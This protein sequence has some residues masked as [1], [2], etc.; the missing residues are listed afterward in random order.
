MLKQRLQ[1][2]VKFHIVISLWRCSVTHI[3]VHMGIRKTCSAQTCTHTHTYTHTHTHTH[4]HNTETDR[5]M[6]Q[7]HACMHA[8]THTRRGF[9]SLSL[10]VSLS[11][12]LFCMCTHC[13]GNGSEVNATIQRW[14]YLCSS[15]CAGVTLWLQTGVGATAGKKGTLKKKKGTSKPGKS[16][17]VVHSGKSLIVFR[18]VL[19]SRKASEVK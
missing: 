14:I 7:T 3:D 19:Q 11:L 8:R 15:H 13:T 10:C 12:T 18:Q 4:T 17:S 5:Q 1:K 6:K 16:L 9:C 2:F